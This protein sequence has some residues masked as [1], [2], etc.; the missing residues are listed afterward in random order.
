VAIAKSGSGGGK[1]NFE[2]WNEPVTI[3]PPRDA[4]DISELRARK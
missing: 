1:V 3:T 4:I 2:R